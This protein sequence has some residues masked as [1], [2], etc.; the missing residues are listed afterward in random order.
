MRSGYCH[1]QI[2]PLVNSAKEFKCSARS[3][4]ANCATIVAIEGHIDSRRAGFC[5]EIHRTALPG[6]VFNDM[7][8]RYIVDQVDRLPL[9]NLDGGLQEVRT[10]HMHGWPR[11]YAALVVNATCG[12]RRRQNA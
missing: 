4:W 12:N 10:S 5:L 9:A 3:E 6:A 2:H 8:Y 11:W 7:L 1:R